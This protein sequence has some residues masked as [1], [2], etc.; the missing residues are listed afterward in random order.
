[1]GSCKYGNR[2]IKV[3]KERRRDRKEREEKWEERMAELPYAMEFL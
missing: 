2:S 3:F 1:V